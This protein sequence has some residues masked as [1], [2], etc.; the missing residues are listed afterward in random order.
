MRIL[1][2]TFILLSVVLAACGAGPVSTDLPNTDAS[3]PLPATESVV[4]AT[5][6][7]GQAGE[8]P[9]PV[10][11]PRGDA[12]EATDPATVSLT[13]GTPTLLEFFRFT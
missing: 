13:S 10:V 7:P 1:F 12:L 11:T 2:P 9:Q 8:Q 5:D 3:Q 6:T 4:L